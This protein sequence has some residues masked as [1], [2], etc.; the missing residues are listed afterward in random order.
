MGHASEY[1]LRA[2]QCT[3]EIEGNAPTVAALLS[4]LKRHGYGDT[5]DDA[6]ISGSFVDISGGSMTL[7]QALVDEGWNV[8]GDHDEFTATDTAGTRIIFRD[9]EIFPG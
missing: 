3:A 5:H 1:A 9:E 4:I 2:E 6:A 7:Y 8:D